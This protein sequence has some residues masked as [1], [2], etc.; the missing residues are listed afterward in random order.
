MVSVSVLI[1][2]KLRSINYHAL[3][4][5]LIDFELVQ[6]F[7]RIDESFRYARGNIQL[8]LIN[9]HATLVLVWP[10][11]DFWLLNSHQLS[12]KLSLPN[13]HQISCKQSRFSTLMQTL[14]SQLSCKLSLLNSHQLSCKLSLLNSHQLSCKLSLL[15]SHAKLRRSFSNCLGLNKT[16][17]K[18]TSP[19]PS[20]TILFRMS[21]DLK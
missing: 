19:L 17:I 16:L 9:S 12:C 5:T 21:F 8:T 13:S 20:S 3:S 7:M 11:H 2:F 18:H 14:A 4:S 15:N 6:I 1:I 10:R